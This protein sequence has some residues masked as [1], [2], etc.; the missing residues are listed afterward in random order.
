MSAKIP[1]KQK[2]KDS[3][4]CPSVLET[5]VLPTELYFHQKAE[6]EGFEPSEPV[7]ARHLSRVLFS[8]AQP[9]F[10]CFDDAK[11][12]RRYAAFLRN[13]NYFKKNTIKRLKSILKA[14]F[15]M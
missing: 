11:V 1:S 14:D 15:P 3:N 13:E 7:T 2:Q 4:L 5:D 9:Y 6:A 10:L 12:E 8:T